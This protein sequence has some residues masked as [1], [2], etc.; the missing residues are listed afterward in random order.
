MLKLY[1]SKPDHLLIQVYCFFKNGIQHIKK[2][3]S[4]PS[5]FHVT[6]GKY[7]FMFTGLCA[8]L[9]ALCQVI[10]TGVAILVVDKFGRRI[11][12]ILSSLLMC[13]SIFALGIYFFMDENKRVI[14]KSSYSKNYQVC[15]YATFPCICYVL[16]LSRLNI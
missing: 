12:L 2:N 3:Y 11:L 6:C 1:S 10:G 5:L 16:I 13:F 15:L 4:I 7:S 8:F 14:C 9:V